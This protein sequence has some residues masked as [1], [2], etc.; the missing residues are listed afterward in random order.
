MYININGYI[1]FHPLYSLNKPS[2]FH[3]LIYL[4]HWNVW[5]G[6]CSPFFTNLS[7]SVDETY[8]VSSKT[9]VENGEIPCLSSHLFG[10]SCSSSEE[11]YTKV[12]LMFER[13]TWQWQ[14]LSRSYPFRFFFP[15]I[16][17]RNEHCRSQKTFIVTNHQWT[18]VHLLEMMR[19]RV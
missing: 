11:K 1:V 13:S 7:V 2:I 19:F 6:R 18:M 4:F 15:H 16:L 12:L 9:F 3:C 14:L 5:E 17:E 8:E 10:V